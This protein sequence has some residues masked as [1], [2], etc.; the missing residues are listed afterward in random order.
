MK[1]K[2]DPNFDY[3][4]SF[5]QDQLTQ[6]RRFG[7]IIFEIFEVFETYGSQMALDPLIDQVL[8]H[9]KVVVRV[10]S[11]A[12][13]LRAGPSIQSP[14]VK[15]IERGAQLLLSDP[16]DESNIGKPGTWLHVMD[17]EGD[18][19]YVVGQYV[20][21]DRD[22]GNPQTKVE[23]LMMT[24][25]SFNRMELV[26]IDPNIGVVYLTTKGENTARL[27]MHNE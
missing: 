2:A 20:F 22:Y 24:L 6:L 21:P 12:L 18:K 10:E 27:L 17:L 19:G 23:A 1:S 14:I 5:V 16:A 15:Q 9:Q 4:H 25:E 3:L 11:D 13:N 8:S 7:P 26:S